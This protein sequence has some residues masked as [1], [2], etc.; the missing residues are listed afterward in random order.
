MPLS[1]VGLPTSEP[2]SVSEFT[3]DD[4]QELSTLIQVVVSDVSDDHDLDTKIIGKPY[5]PPVSP[6]SE[7][8]RSLIPQVANDEGSGSDT[9]PP[10]MDDTRK[11][12]LDDDDV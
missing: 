12:S 5:R 8:V 6:V 7:E 4:D 3:T 11:M 1:D 9:P 2:D 10:P